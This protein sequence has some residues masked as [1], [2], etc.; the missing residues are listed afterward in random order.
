MLKSVTLKLQET[1]QEVPGWLTSMAARSG[2][3]GGSKPR[4][5]GGGSRFGGRDFRQDR[6]GGSYGGGGGG[7]DAGCESLGYWRDCM[8]HSTKLVKKRFACNS[9]G[10]AN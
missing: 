9:K 7:Y 4:R 5:G 6:G 10:S 1:N 3:F 8:S 2:S